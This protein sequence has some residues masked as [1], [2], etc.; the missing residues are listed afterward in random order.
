FEARIAGA[1]DG[2]SITAT[3]AYWGGPFIVFTGDDLD[4][5]DLYFISKFNEDGDEP[6][7]D[8]DIR[9]LQITYNDS[10]V[11]SGNY[12]FGGESPVTAE[13]IEIEGGAM[14]VYRATEGTLEVNNA[15]EGELSDGKF[16][17]SFEENGEDLGAL[18][19]DFTLP[20]CTNLKSRY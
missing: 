7:V 16:A 6:L 10:D 19:G 4:C 14:R 17:F 20:W 1:V 8:F 12:D 11:V 9:V 3:T 5:E 2:L 18:T 13:V 15:E